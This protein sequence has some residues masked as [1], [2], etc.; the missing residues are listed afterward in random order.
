MQVIKLAGHLAR[1]VMWDMHTTKRSQENEKEI[2]NWE[3]LD[4][5]GAVMLKLI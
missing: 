2:D 4:V 5:D 3:N 1:S